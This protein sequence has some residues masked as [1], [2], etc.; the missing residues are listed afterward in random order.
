[1]RI[2]NDSKA[3]NADAAEKALLSFD[4]IRWIAGGLPKEGGI[5]TLRPL[6]SRI[7]KAY[8]IGTAAE[9]F[10]ETLAD[11]PH[12]ISGT[13]DAAVRQALAE[14]EE[15]D[16]LLLAP[17]CASFDQYESFEHRGRAFEEAVRAVI[18]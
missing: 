18:G 3:T 6:F 12:V 13:L 9:D 5:E 15:G 7:A 10:G 8:L 11:T 17:A 2:I 16:V 1:M 14:A 4:R